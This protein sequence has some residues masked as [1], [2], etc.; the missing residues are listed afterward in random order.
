MSRFRFEVWPTEY[1]QITQY[2]GASPQNFAQFGLPGH[3]GVDIEAPSGSA[4]FSVAPGRVIF[5]DPISEDPRHGIHVRVSHQDGYQTLYAHLDRA[6]VQ[7]DQLVDAGATVGL[8]GSTGNSFYP[9]LHL[10][11]QKSGARQGDWPDNLIDPTPFLLPLLGW[12]DPKGPFVDGW[13]RASSLFVSG[14][15]A[16]VNA[17]GALLRVS[18]ELSVPIPAG[19][20]LL[21]V[22]QDAAES[23]AYL[24]A[25]VPYVSLGNTTPAPPP[26][27]ADTMPPPPAVATLEGWGRGAHLMIAGP[28]AVVSHHGLNL[29]DGPGPDSALLGLVRRGSVVTVLGEAVGPY[30]P[31]AVRRDYFVGN[32]AV[33]LPMEAQPERA[34]LGWVRNHYLERSGR[35]ALVRYAGIDLRS[36]PRDGAPHLGLVKGFATVALAGLDRTGYT[37]VFVRDEDILSP[38]SPPP[39]LEAPQPLPETSAPPVPTVLETTPGWLFTGAITREGEAATVRPPGLNL[40]ALP[41]RDAVSRGFVPAGT[42]VVVGGPP[43]GEYTPVRAAD[44][45][46]EAP[47]PDIFDTPLLGGALL[48]LHA[49]ADPDISD[50]EIE[51]FAQLRPGIV[52][53]LSFHQPEAISRLVADHPEARWVLRAFLDFGGR[54]ITPRQ[55]FGDTIDDVKRALGALRGRDVVVELHNEPNITAEGFGSAWRDGAAFAE[56]WLALLDL[57]RDAIPSARFLYPGLSPGASVAGVKQDHVEF[58]EASR[59]AVKQ[60]DGLGVHLYWSQQYPVRAS[61]D[62]LDDIIDRFRGYPLWVTEASHNGVLHPVLKAQQ[63]LAFWQ[64]LQQRPAVQGVTFFVA[65]AS[66][67]KFAEE[68]W[69]GRGIADI[70]GRR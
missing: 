20:V 47:R 10:G 6:L 31:V 16:Q 50:E 18:P 46:L 30:Y 37:P 43:Q 40:R 60:A 68:V 22:S 24:R 65:S 14:N 49:S 63:Y 41:R 64:A 12:H 42:R 34:F 44:R 66:N 5:V 8:V 69:V 39:P 3:D 27:P 1:R 4:V 35:Q 45:L 62:V 25:L 53:L 52:K 55:F 13:V 23:P 2:F 59:A 36:A 56:W 26:R 9:H 21:V 32:V 51:T 19:T 33:P 15:Q 58:L 17:G 28:Q 57:Y 29:R 67:P 54:A 11:L 7:P 61:L 38:V 48:G 70:V